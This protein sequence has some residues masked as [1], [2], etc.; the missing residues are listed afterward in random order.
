MKRLLLLIFPLFFCV[1]TANGQARLLSDVETQHLG[2]IQWKRPV[3]VEYTISNAGN[4]PL[5]LTNITTSCAC[6]VADWT[7]EP[8]MPDGKGM[9]RVVF[10]AEALGRFHKTVGIYSNSTPGLVYLKFVG[11]VVQEV[12]DYGHA[13]PFRF[14]QIQIDKTEIEFPD[15]NRGEQPQVTLSIIN[16]SDR[17]YEPV[18]MHL[19]PYL[20]MEKYPQTLKKGERGTITLT[21]DSERLDDFGLFQTSVYL[22]RFAGDKVGPEN[23]LPV[24]IV[25]LPDFSDLTAK[26]QANPPVIGLSDNAIDFGPLLVNKEK[27]H[28]DITVRNNGKSTLKIKKLQ[29]FNPAVEVSLK[30]ASLKPGQSTRLRVELDKQRLKNSKRHLRVLIITNDPVTPKKIIPIKADTPAYI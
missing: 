16:S 19:P 10:D 29:V 17:P 13:H 11:E 3:T 23:E 1:I 30:K 2:Q 6:A 7:K 14:G 8:I 26:Q 4:E 20:R 27:I 24:S 28:Y 15:V 21:L 25:L 5:V 18:I 12:V 9:I 22:S